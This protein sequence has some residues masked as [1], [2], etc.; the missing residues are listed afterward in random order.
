MKLLVLS[1]LA[2]LFFDAP[3]TTV[4]KWVIEKNSNL[5][6]EG[7]SNV[8][9]FQCDVVRYLRADTIFFYKENTRIYTTK[10]GLTIDVNE[11]DCHHKYITADLKKTLKAK[12]CPLLRIELLSIGNFSTAAGDQKT[13]GCVSIQLAGITRKFEINYAIQSGNEGALH[14]Y[15]SRKVSFSDF[16]LTPPRK[17]AGLIK[18]E[19]EINVSFRLILRSV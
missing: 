18:V 14:L 10:G 2:T 11:F 19:E 3:S 5:S 6:I 12:E 7:R 8:S 1:F 15:G 13:T 16:G 9:S 17:L 4:E